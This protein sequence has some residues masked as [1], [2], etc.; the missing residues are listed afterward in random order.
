MSNTP[1][2]QEKRK[3]VVI[4]QHKHI[5]G[6][7]LCSDSIKLSAA[8]REIQKQL[9]VPEP[10]AFFSWVPSLNMSIEATNKQEEI[11]ILQDSLEDGDIK[12]CTKSP[13][14]NNNNNNNEERAI[15]GSIGSLLVKEE[16]KPIQEPEESSEEMPPPRPLNRQ[17]FAVPKKVGKEEATPKKS[18]PKKKISKKRKSSKMEEENSDDEGTQ[19][20]H[21]HG[22]Y[23]YDATQLEP[24]DGEKER[25][26]GRKRESIP[27]VAR[28]KESI[29]ELIQRVARE[30]DVDAVASLCRDYP[31][32]DETENLL[33]D[34]AK[35]GNLRIFRV[36]FENGHWNEEIYNKIKKKAISNLRENI[37]KFLV[38]KDAIKITL[39]DITLATTKRVSDKN[40]I[41]FLEVNC[42]D[43]NTPRSKRER[44]DLFLLD[45][46]SSDSEAIEP[47]RWL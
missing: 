13:N 41:K 31:D 37:I 45:W 29:E 20:Y 11:L 16:R 43:V 46:G 22:I 8:R 10:F 3:Y 15:A 42:Q 27:K 19:L 12:I 4:D 21:A 25:D 34:V 9:N 17:L 18:Q 40:F 35:A 47:H 38:N 39:D 28:K 2:K 44:G 6:F 26:S 5:F 30:E 23:D 14:D 24:K 1:K 36:F 33:L 7:L 32:S